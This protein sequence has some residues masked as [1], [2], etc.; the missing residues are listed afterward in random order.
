M[1]EK[2]NHPRVF[3]FYKEIVPGTNKVKWIFKKRFNK[4]PQDL[5]NETGFIRVMS[6]DFEQYIDIN[7]GPNQFVIR[8]TTTD[9]I[10]NVI[11]RDLMDPNKGEIHTI[12][13]RFKWIDNN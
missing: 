8:N 9:V 4:Y 13:N 3:L 5:E 6:P 1:L 12:M 11:S 7:R 2:L 10:I